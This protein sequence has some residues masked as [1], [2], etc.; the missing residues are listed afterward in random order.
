MLVQTLVAGSGNYEFEQSHRPSQPLCP[1]GVRVA[2]SAT[3]L[4]FRNIH[5]SS[6]PSDPRFQLLNFLLL[7]SQQP[8]CAK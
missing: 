2:V 5:F 6:K 3:A 7:W 4:N 1:H 8:C